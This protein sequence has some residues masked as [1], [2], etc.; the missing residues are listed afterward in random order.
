[1]SAAK[2]KRRLSD[3]FSRLLGISKKRASQ[4]IPANITS[5][6]AYEAHV[7]SVICEELKHKEGCTL[8]LKNG[9]NIVLKTGGGGINRNYPW[10]EV[11]R[12][13]NPIGEIFTDIYF[14]SLS[15]SLNGGSSTPT[16]GEYHE[17]DIVMTNHGAAGMPRH[18]EILI[19]VECKHTEYNKSLL[20]E[21]LGVRREMGYLS[22]ANNTIFSKW[23][24]S[25]IPSDPPSCLLVYSSSN[26][27]STYSAPGKT[28]GI[29]FTHETM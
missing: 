28:F 5:G 8:I 16:P 12:N 4:L 24:S 6:K 17:L 18:D 29:E 13:G 7:L 10:I 2:I 11:R 1:M 9:S 26:K 3:A 23:P 21:I 14:I 27:V 25:N 20:K 15:H 19:G 22:G